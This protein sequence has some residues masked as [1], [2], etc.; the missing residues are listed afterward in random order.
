MFLLIP[1]LRHKVPIP[2]RSGTLV[3][4]EQ[5]ADC[6]GG[7]ACTAVTKTD[8]PRYCYLVVVTILI[9]HLSWADGWDEAACLNAK[10]T[11]NKTACK[12]LPVQ[13]SCPR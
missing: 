8:Q 9:N 13:G 2:P 7:D 11:D 4:N 1:G 6:T 3:S 5:L 12:Y 10:K